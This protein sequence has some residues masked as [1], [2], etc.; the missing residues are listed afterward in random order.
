MKVNSLKFKI[1]S[2]TGIL[3]M[4]MLMLVGF[5]FTE[6]SSSQIPLG[7][8]V[9]SLINLLV[10]FI[11]Y[12]TLKRFIDNIIV[13]ELGLIDFFDFLN[14]KTSTCE[15]IDINT[16]DEIGIMATMINN[17]IQTVSDNIQKDNDLIENTVKIASALKKGHLKSRIK[18]SSNNEELNKLKDVIND[19]LDTLY[20]KINEIVTTVNYY[21]EYDYT[22]RVDVS[23]MSAQLK[24]L[25]VDV[26][27]VGE[28]TT[29]MLI[30]NKRNGLILD[31]YSDLLMENMNEINDSVRTQAVS[32]QQTKAS[33]EEIS[34]MIRETS[35]KSQMMS[36]LA[37]QTKHSASSGKDL[38]QE[39]A[40]A[41]DEINI[42]TSSISEAISV[43]DQIAFQTNIL[44]LN[45]AVEAATAGEAGKGFAVVAGE[46]RNLASRSAEAADEIKKLVLQATQKAQEGKNITNGMIEGY[47]KL[48]GD[49][50]QTTELIDEVSNA[51]QRQ[52]QRIDQINTAIADIDTVT[53][54][55]ALMAEDTNQLAIDTDRIAKD[56]VADM[57]AL[58]FEGKDEINISDV[59]N[60]KLERLNRV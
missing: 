28:M 8:I 10:L 4:T 5:I 54:K 56:V 12:S 41:M 22:K 48:D 40:N 2:L 50:V 13:V 15:T 9:I 18:K 25:G 59:P 38:A 51:A 26:N 42:A 14:R 34:T 20:E 24:D 39:T 55:N 16:K 6:I 52:L 19:M 17:N 37:T 29:K 58:Q 1:Y 27:R 44:S 49:I 31:D 23:T 53:Q 32:L 35:D 11:L 57:D 33:I 60:T 36:N 43:I 46:V 7:L 21:A 30:I 47:E 3:L 45:A